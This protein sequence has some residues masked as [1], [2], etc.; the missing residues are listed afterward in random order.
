MKVLEIIS[1]LD[2][3][4]GAETFAVNFSIEMQHISDLKVVV[5]YRKHKDYFE[6]KLKENNVDYIFLN[7]AKRFDLKNVKELR[8]IIKEYKPD[9]IHTENNALIPTFLALRMLK[10]AQRPNVFHTMHLKAEDETS[11]KIVRI[12]FKHIFKK[13]NFIP[14]A[15]TKSLAI[16]SQ[17]FY[18]VN[19]VP[20]VEN[21]VSL[22]PFRTD[23]PLISRT[24]DVVVVGRFAPQKNH[25]F[26]VSSFLELKKK[27]PNLRVALVGGGELLDD[28]KKYVSDNNAQDFINFTGILNSPADIVNDSKIIALGSLFEANPLSLLEG[29]SAGCIVVSSNVGGVAD[30]IKEGKNG[31]LFNSGDKDK[32]VEILSE[33]LSNVENYQNMSGFNVD[34]SNKFSMKECARKYSELF[35]ENLV[36]RK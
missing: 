33:I 23:K 25:F 36:P 13:P 18:K 31:F 21:G 17:N 9:V 14:V 6:E 11:S 27:I 12:L 8:Q 15:I 4:G 3:T 32:F 16:E 7:K 30:I 28:V 5:L 20:Y 1:S 2:P 34:Y 22:E 10:K 35:G 24:Y 26:V 29:M 19:Y